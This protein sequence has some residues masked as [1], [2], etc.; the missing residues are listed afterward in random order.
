MR[1]AH[2]SLVETL[3]DEG[4]AGNIIVKCIL[5]SKVGAFGVDIFSLGQVTVAETFEDHVRP[6]GSISAGKFLD[7]LPD[8]SRLNID[9]AVWTL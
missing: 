1:N 2:K 9:H 8:C 7:N 5:R 4:L 3:E 6:S